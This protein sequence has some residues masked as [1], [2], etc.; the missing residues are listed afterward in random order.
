[1]SGPLDGIR[2]LDM[3]W[4]PEAV[5]PLYEM[6]VRMYCIPGTPTYST[7]V[8]LDDV[9]LRTED[10]ERTHIRADFNTDCKFDLVR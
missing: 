9:E 10:F 5:P 4:D 3:G 7:Y 6:D 8:A 2:V 1:M